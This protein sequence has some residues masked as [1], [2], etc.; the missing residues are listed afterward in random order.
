MHVR[1]HFV[2]VEISSIQLSSRTWGGGGGLG[3]SKSSF[4]Q[5]AESAELRERL[6]ERDVFIKYLARSRLA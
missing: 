1:G 4:Q 2:L 5:V 3:D 6:R